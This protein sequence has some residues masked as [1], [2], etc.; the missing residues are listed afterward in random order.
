M[1]LWQSNARL[2]LDCFLVEDIDIFATFS[3]VYV[4]YR[5]ITHWVMG[6]LLLLVIALIIW[7]LY[8]CVWVWVGV[9]GWRP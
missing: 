9:G 2:I 4:N 8:V 6:L 3:L 1:V 5:K 7:T